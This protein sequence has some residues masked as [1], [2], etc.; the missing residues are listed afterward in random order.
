VFAPHG[1]PPSLALRKPARVL[2][3]EDDHVVA[4]DIESALLD[5]GF[6]VVGVAATADDAV[7]MAQAEKPDL[8][9]MDIRL[10]GHRDGIDAALELLKKQGV[11][12]IFATAHH[13]AAT[14]LRAQP[15]RPLGWV[16]KPYQAEAVVE[17]VREALDDLSKP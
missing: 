17:A 11:R 5:A 12:C 8:A 2:V 13:D 10:A 9:I 14:R 3:V 7:A 4:T 15:A 1:D 6:D 16:S